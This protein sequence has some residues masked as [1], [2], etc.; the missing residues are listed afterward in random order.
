MLIETIMSDMHVHEKIIT[1]Q[2]LLLNGLANS[3]VRP[4]PNRFE[5]ILRE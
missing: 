5:H 3:L 1:S 2:L 4:R